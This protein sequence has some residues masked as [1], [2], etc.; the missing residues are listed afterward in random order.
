MFPAL[1][2]LDESDLRQRPFVYAF[3]G[4]RGQIDVDVETIAMDA[5]ALLTAEFLGVLDAYLANYSVVVPHNLLGWLL[6]EKAKTLFHQPSR[7]VVAKEL[8]QMMNDDLLRSFS[9]SAIPPES[10]VVEVGDSLAAMLAEASAGSGPEQRLVVRGGPIHKVG[11]LMNE[12]VDVAGFEERLCSSFDVVDKLLAKGQLTSVEAEA[13]RA[14]LTSRERPWPAPKEIQDGA[15]LYLDDLAVSHLQFLGLLGKLKRAGVTAVVSPTEKAEADNLIAFDRMNAD[16]SGVVESLRAKVRD[17]LAT[18]SVR[19]SQSIRVDDEESLEAMVGHPTMALL[20]AMG[21]AEAAI[22]DDRFVNQHPRITSDGGTRPL[23][24]SLDGL[25]LLAKKNAITA[26][27]K[28]EALTKL[29]RANFA[30]VPVT[31]DELS[32]LLALTTAKDG[33]LVESA[34][35]RAIREN[36]QRVRMSKILQIPKEIIWLNGLVG[37]CL[38]ALKDQWVDGV[39]FEVAQ[40]RSDWLVDLGDPAGWTHRLSETSA[41]RAQRS[42]HWAGTL[43]ALPAIQPDSVKDAYWQWFD[44]RILQRM[45]EEDPDGYAALLERARSMV[46]EGVATTSAE[47]EGDDE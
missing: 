1:A 34:E 10:L 23:L 5:T 6:E 3:S 40:A 26:A 16:V 20:K 25:D 9:G 36:I 47:M 13:A 19:L 7:V 31:L 24:S 27:Q 11:S 43:M 35:L 45:E 44:G 41:E 28:Q 15:I 2:N 33:V 22:V 12:L 38:I 32:H 4:A 39:D 8:R 21:G 30:F 46:D 42:R 29:R 17:G 14:G 18:G 37:T